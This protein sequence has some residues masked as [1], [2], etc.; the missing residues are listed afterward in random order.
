MCLSANTFALCPVH[1][2][3]GRFVFPDP[4]LSKFQIEKGIC[5]TSF[6]RVP[7]LYATHWE[8]IYYIIFVILYST[9]YYQLFL[10]KH[11]S[12]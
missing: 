8:L 3:I 10:K 2:P 7:V 5:E 6:S 12:G 11:S 1:L 4:T 9:A